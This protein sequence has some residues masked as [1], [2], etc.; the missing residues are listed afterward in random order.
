[1][2][3]EAPIMAVIP[4]EDLDR[5]LAFYTDILG[6]EA[7]TDKRLGIPETARCAPN[8]APTRR[9]HVLIY[10]SFALQSR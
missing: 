9:G 1:M 7:A 3:S 8:H 5:A 10:Q 4:A 6:L 2:L